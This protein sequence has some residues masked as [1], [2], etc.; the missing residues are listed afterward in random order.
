[1]ILLG[2]V[3]LGIVGT[4]LAGVGILCSEGMIS[5][6][7]ETKQPEKHHIFVM[8][9]AMLVPIGLYFVPKEHLEQQAREIQ[10]W[11]PT[12]R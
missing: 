3:G 7:V 1:M 10:P 5:V 12:I 6:N 11:M 9:P 2:K 4:A 8:A